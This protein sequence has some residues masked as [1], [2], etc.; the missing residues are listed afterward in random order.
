MTETTEAA[1]VTSPSSSATEGMP[2]QNSELSEQKVKILMEVQ[3]AAQGVR[4]RTGGAF[5]EIKKRL[6]QKLDYI[7]ETLTK[8]GIPLLRFSGTG[9]SFLA[10]LLGPTTSWLPRISLVA[11]GYGLDRLGRRH[12]NSRISRL[13]QA[14]GNGVWKGG[15]FGWLT[16]V[17][18]NKVLPAGVVGDK[19]IS[20]TTTLPEAT[21]EVVSTL[22]KGGEEISEKAAALAEK[23]GQSLV[24]EMTGGTIQTGAEAV[25]AVV[26]PEIQTVTKIGEEAYYG[27]NQ[28]LKSPFGRL[29]S[30]IGLSTVIYKFLQKIGFYK[31]TSQPANH[32]E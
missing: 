17:V 2:S 24:V 23:V 27:L 18:V 10:E 4:E 11:A 21:H 3:K 28:F 19:Q 5:Q 6:G 14:L 29:T 31:K 7:L 20:P 9:M 1:S 30:T 25:S 22:F 8:A 16:N 13:A 26:G 12:P 32:A 15:V